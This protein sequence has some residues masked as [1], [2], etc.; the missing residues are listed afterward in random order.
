LEIIPNM[1][2]TLQ[3]KLGITVDTVNTNKHSDVGSM[4][5][6]VSKDEY[7]YIQTS[8]EKCTTYLQSV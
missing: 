2:K 1:Q 3:D 5:R 8:V 7:N 4:L 6:A